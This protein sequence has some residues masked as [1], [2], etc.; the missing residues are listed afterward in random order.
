[1]TRRDTPAGGDFNWVAPLYDALSFLVFG[2]RLQKAQTVFLD[3]IPQGASVLIIG[4]GTGWLL[5][6]VLAKRLIRHSQ[7]IPSRPGPSR[8]DRILY[9]ETSV[10]MLNRASQRMLRK[11]LVGSVEFRLG[12]ETTLGENDCFDVVITPFLLD[13]FTEETLQTRVIPRLQKA[14]KP[15]GCWLVTDFVKTQAK[16]QKA[17][18]WMM[19]RFFRL[20]A[21]IE[22]HQLA[23]WQ[24]LLTQAGLTLMER[25]A[26]VGGMVSTEVYRRDN[27]ATLEAITDSV[28]SPLR[29]ATH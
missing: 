13:L 17:V 11:P 26:R 19:I 6:Q 1:M 5:E 7:S 12:D 28:T 10:Q 24:R 2:R 14:L 4:G 20:T 22:T 29:R 21:G 27:R 16:W 8:R 9:L 15:D 18:L 23:D 3:R 25:Q